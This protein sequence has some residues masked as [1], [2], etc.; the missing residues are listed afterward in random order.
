MYMER[1]FKPQPSRFL[2]DAYTGASSD[3]YKN[4]P[5]NKKKIKQ[6]L[7]YT[8]DRSQKSAKAEAKIDANVSKLFKSPEVIA[9]EKLIGLKLKLAELRQNQTKE[10]REEANKIR[11]EIIALESSQEIH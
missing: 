4:D 11:K 2:N 6:V 7:S 10:N 1:E 8:P 9:V 5:E 3:K